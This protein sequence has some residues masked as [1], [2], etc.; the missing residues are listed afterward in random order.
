[1][2]K[3]EIITYEKIARLLHS[4]GRTDGDEEKAVRSVLANVSAGDTVLIRFSCLLDTV[5]RCLARDM[6]ELRRE[7]E[8][9]AWD[10]EKNRWLA[11]EE[12]KHGPI[13][14]KLLASIDADIRR[15]VAADARQIFGD[16]SYTPYPFRAPEK[17]TPLRVEWDRW[18]KRR[19]RKTKNN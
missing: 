5:V 13:P 9:L 16:Y 18:K 7:A 12:G 14:E 19:V 1:M 10:D 17:G 11:E 3:K 2:K 15:S 4:W 6:F 8:A